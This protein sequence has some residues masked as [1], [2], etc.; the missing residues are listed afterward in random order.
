MQPARK[1]SLFLIELMIAILFFAVSVSVCIK[2]FA[3]SYEQTKASEYG[4][5]AVMQAQSVAEYFR[6]V[7]GDIDKLV[8]FTNADQVSEREYIGSIEGD[9][10]L[11]LTIQGEELLPTLKIEIV[12]PESVEVI[13]TLCTSVYQGIA[14]GM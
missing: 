2:V 5:V 10:E 12:P 4:N 6:N 9:Y 13:F 7:N 1:S 14:M 3:L 11:L 8:S